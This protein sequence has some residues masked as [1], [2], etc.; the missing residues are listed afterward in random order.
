MDLLIDDAEE[1]TNGED[2]LKIINSSWTKG[3]KVTSV[4]EN[5]EDNIHL[6]FHKKKGQHIATLVPGK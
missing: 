5:E 2:E 1:K 4:M 3:W 6:N